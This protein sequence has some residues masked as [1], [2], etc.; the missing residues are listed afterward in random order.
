MLSTRG[1]VLV[2]LL[3]GGCLAAPG[4]APRLVEAS[5]ARVAPDGGPFEEVGA[6]GDAAPAKDVTV[7]VDAPVPGDVPVPQDAMG[8]DDAADLSGPA[9][10]RWK[11]VGLTWLFGCAL[12]VDGAAYCWG[13]HSYGIGTGAPPSD[14]VTRRPTAVQTTQVF[15]QIAVGRRHACGA[16][17]QGVWCWGGNA[18]GQVNGVADNDIVAAPIAT[19]TFAGA[20]ESLSAG[21]AQTCV[22]A[23]SPAPPHVFCWG[24]NNHL[25]SGG[26]TAAPSFR[27]PVAMTGSPRAA[28]AGHYTVCAVLADS[29]GCWGHGK[30]ADGIPAS[31]LIP[32]G[33]AG[34]SSDCSSP[35]VFGESIPAFVDVAVGEGHACAVRDDGG[36][37]CWGSNDYLGDPL[38]GRLGV[39][40]LQETPA[41]TKLT[42]P[43]GA[44]F[45]EGSVSASDSHT[46]AVSAAGRMYCW[47]WNDW[48]GAGPPAGGERT[49]PAR[50][51][52]RTDWALVA[53]GIGSSCA[54]DTSG[55][56]YCWG[57]DQNGQLADGEKLGGADTPRR[58]ADPI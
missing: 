29:V 53:A 52:D 48:G 41:P 15:D 58:V 13:R 31:A 18:S 20:V 30:T 23:L 35:A 7:V 33:A 4:G 9:S 5:D 46:C 12:D 47:G 14:D 57:N 36:I 43:D 55:R 25:Q 40:D 2:S 24:A 54:I 16:N 8:V 27:G 22:I 44:R 32:E 49:V 11:D 17:T 38:S 21:F 39:S 10:H 51:D 3:L 56:M 6:R 19:P 42:F 1:F 28:A 34:C 37:W 50:V 45:E 26:M